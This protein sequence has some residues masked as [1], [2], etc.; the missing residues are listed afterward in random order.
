M[1]SVLSHVSCACHS[2]RYPRS[3]QDA[4][5]KFALKTPF[6]TRYFQYYEEI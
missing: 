2:V 5:E 4:R 1:T 6:I 3:P